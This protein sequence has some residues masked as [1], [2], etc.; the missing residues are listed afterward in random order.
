MRAVKGLIA[1]CSI[2][3]AQLA[4]SFS[5]RNARDSFFGFEPHRVAHVIVLPHARAAREAQAGPH[6]SQALEEARVLE[7]L[8]GD[9]DPRGLAPHRHHELRLH[10]APHAGL[11]GRTPSD[12]WA[13]AEVDPE[14]DHLDEEAIRRALTVHE[15]RRV[16]RDN[17]LSV[18]GQ[19]FQLDQGF[20]AG[21]VVTAAYCMLDEPP[22]P[23]V[24]A[25]EKQYCLH[26]VDPILN[27]TVKR[28]PRREATTNTPSIKATGFNPAETLLRQATGRLPKKEK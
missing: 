2:A 6:P 22:E 15:R 12:V 4:H 1:R 18:A 14:V 24:V 21:R 20:L 9:H 25:D 5:A 8:G 27:A 16:R 26:L 3:Y 11:F 13:E 19:T 7:G 17:T 10:R 23:V 28:P